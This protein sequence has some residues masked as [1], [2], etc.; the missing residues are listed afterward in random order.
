MCIRDRYAA[1]LGAIVRFLP[2]FLPSA[3]A[4][5]LSGDCPR[6]GYASCKHLR[7]PSHHECPKHH[8][9]HFSL[10]RC[11]ILFFGSYSLAWPTPTTLYQQ[12]A[13]SFG[14]YYDH[15]MSQNI[16]HLHIRTCDEGGAVPHQGSWPPAGAPELLIRFVANLGAVVGVHLSLIHISEPTRPY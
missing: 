15:R 9:S 13:S 7:T 11:S 14:A 1:A 6:S 5:S 3:I 4:C 10:S 12:Q 2:C 16:L 8:T